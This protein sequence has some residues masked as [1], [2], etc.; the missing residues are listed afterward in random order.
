MRKG[1]VLLIVMMI[2]FMMGTEF[3]VLNSTSNFAAI[4]TNNA[5]LQ[6]DEQNLISSGLALVKLNKYEAGRVIDLE[7][8]D[9]ASSVAKMSIKIENPKEVKISTF[10][11]RG[12]R[13]LKSTKRFMSK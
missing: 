8:A 1:F 4:E 13:E 9:L 11:R 12:G 5:F 10:N 2:L 3:L 7:T 6:A